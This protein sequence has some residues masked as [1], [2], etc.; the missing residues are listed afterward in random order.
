MLNKDMKRGSTQF[1]TRE[2]QIKATKA[3]PYM[4]VKMTKKIK[5]ALPIAD[6][7]VEQP[8]LAFLAENAKWYSHFGGQLSSFLQ[9]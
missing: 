2:L 4:P 6:K 1:V 7:D 9:S 5:T 8:E 3:Y